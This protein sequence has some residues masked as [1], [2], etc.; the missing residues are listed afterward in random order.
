MSLLALFKNKFLDQ[1]NMII[2]EFLDKKFN[3]DNKIGHVIEPGHHYEWAWLLSWA[4]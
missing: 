4:T 1:K 2:R 3:P